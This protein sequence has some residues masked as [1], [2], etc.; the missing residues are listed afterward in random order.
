MKSLGKGLSILTLLFFIN[1]CSSNPTDNENLYI[2]EVNGPAGNY[3]GAT[4]FVPGMFSAQQ[5]IYTYDEKNSKWYGIIFDPN[6]E[7]TYEG[8][9]GITIE[10]TYSITDGRM[11]VTDADQN[12]TIDLK[13]AKASTFEVTGEDHDG[14]I[15][16][17]KWYLELKF[18]P[19]MLEGK[20][21]LSTYNDR[22]EMVNEKVCLSKTTLDTYRMD[23][24]LKHSY[25]YI[26]Q[27]SILAVKGDDGEFTLHLMFI[28]QAHTLNVWYV[29]KAEN[30]ANNASWTLMK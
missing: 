19:E 14:R 22:G 3:T 2:Q 5:A 7:M 11:Y 18:K 27:N 17:D 28:G 25:P 1:G 21:Y 16:Q 13:I 30:Y 9:E 26:L 23:G 4:E 6:G 8:T 29:S 12:P 20:C 10:S 24:I 15:W